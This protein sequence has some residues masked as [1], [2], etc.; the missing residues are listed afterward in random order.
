M[1]VP[2][3]KEQYCPD[4]DKNGSIDDRFRVVL[5]LLRFVL[6]Q[7]SLLGLSEQSLLFEGESRLLLVICFPDIKPLKGSSCFTLIEVVSDEVF[8]DILSFSHGKPVLTSRVFIDIVG[9]II[10]LILKDPM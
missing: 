7:Q 5:K 10:K 6:L 8:S 4:N 1:K 3:H 9:Q 2:S